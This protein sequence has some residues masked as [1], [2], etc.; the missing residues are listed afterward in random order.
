MV[1]DAFEKKYVPRDNGFYRDHYHH[2]L[3]GV[4]IMVL[5]LIIIM[6]II[7]YQVAH[8]P[9]PQFKARQADGATMILNP[10]TMPNQLPD[11]ILRWA[12]KAAALAYTFDFL[13][14]NQQATMV[15]P[16]FT[17]EGW[18]DY[19]AS[20]RSLIATVIKNQLFVNGVVTG[21]PV[22]ANQGPLDGK[23]VW[24]VQIPFLVTYQSANTISTRHFYV[25]ITIIRVPTVANPQGVGI[26]QFVMTSQG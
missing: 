15:R 18:R 12:S 11:T 3:Q 26:D 20:V 23:Y 10:T 9:L 7:F 19:L 13:N 6:A 5:L 2:M 17:D 1:L 14:Y 21:V 22:I 24:R 16:Y 8:R 4:M 25:V